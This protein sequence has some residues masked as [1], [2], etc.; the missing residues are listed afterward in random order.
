MIATVLILMCQPA[1]VAPVA[2]AQS[3]TAPRRVIAVDF[4]V[5][6]QY[7]SCRQ[8]DFVSTRTVL[9][10]DSY[11]MSLGALKPATDGRVKTSR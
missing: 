6:N 8:R 7:C 5:V 9:Y 3:I 4:V 2:P 11:W 10:Y 1:P